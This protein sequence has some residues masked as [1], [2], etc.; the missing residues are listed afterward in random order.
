MKRGSLVVLGFFS[1]LSCNCRDG[2]GAGGPH[3]TALPE[4]LRQPV[5]LTGETALPFPS[6]TAVDGRFLYWL[7]YDQRAFNRMPKTGAPAQVLASTGSQPR[8]LQLDETHAYWAEDLPQVRAGDRMSAIASVAK[9]GGQPVELAR[10]EGEITGV[11]VDQEDVYFTTWS[12]VM[13][14]PKTGGTPVELGSSQWAFAIVTD[15]QAAYVADYRAET[16]RRI[17][18]TDG[19]VTRLADRQRGPRSLTADTTSLYWVTFDKRLMRVS[20][21]GGAPAV[22]LEDV[23]VYDACTNAIAVDASDL[24]VTACCDTGSLTGEIIR[25]PS[26]GGTPVVLA[27]ELYKP[28]NPVTDDTSVYWGTTTVATAHALLPGGA[29]FRIGK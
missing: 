13:R 15:H 8:Q 27:K 22:L 6:A 28:C 19:M 23:G 21:A 10:V 18:K 17:S 4:R 25:V 12:A 11:A 29:L 9:D 24:Y 5:V 7:N 1:F 14:V 20:K 26:G 16:I 3:A 2:C